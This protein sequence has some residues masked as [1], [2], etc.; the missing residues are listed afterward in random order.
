MTRSTDEVSLQRT[1]AVSVIRF[2]DPQRRN[3][4]S[5]AILESFLK[6]LEE[7]ANDSQ[8]M[9][10]RLEGAGSAFCSGIDLEA[11]REDPA[12]LVRLLE[13]LSEAMRS[14]RSMSKVVVA[15]VQGAAIAGGCALLSA[16]D[17]TCGEPGTRVG[18]PV[19]RVG[20]SAAVSVPTLLGSVG[21]AAARSL[22]LEGSVIDGAEARRLNLLTHLA[23]S[24]DGLPGLVDELCA[25]LATKAPIAM[26]KTKAWLN[27]L[28]ESVEQSRHRAALDHSLQ[29]ARTDEA[30]LLLER[31]WKNKKRDRS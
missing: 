6:R 13:L 26:S 12:L 14:I 9:I 11:G 30:A 28:D 16:C 15:Q 23:S 7:V 4:L 20:L 18:Y 31:N 25:D 24:L 22:L 1:A 29:S 17:F 2:E 27:E 21:P 19:T 8:T 5:I 10:V 3:A